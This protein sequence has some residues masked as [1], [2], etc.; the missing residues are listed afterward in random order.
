MPLCLPC[1]GFAVKEG[2]MKTNPSAREAGLRWRSRDAIPRARAM[3]KLRQ[4]RDQLQAALDALSA[5]VSWISSDLKYLGGNRYLAEILHLPQAAFA[6][7]EVGFQGTSPDLAEFARGFFASPAQQASREITSQVDGAIRRY[8]VVARKYQGGQAAAFV[9]MDITELREAGEEIRK[10][11]QELERRVAERTAQLAAANQELQ[12]EVVRR[13]RAEEKALRALDQEKELSDLKSRFISMTSHEFRTPLSMIL[14]S[15][16]LLEQ[17][18]HQL[19][20]ERVLNHLRRIQA[21]AKQ[22]SDLLDDVLIVAKSDVGKLTFTPGPLD[23]LRFCEELV[24]EVQLTIG[25]GHTV[26]FVHRGQ[27]PDVSMDESLLRQILYNLLSNAIH[28]SD[29]GSTVH[30]ELT[31]SDDR[32]TFRVSDQGIGI[33]PEE[34]ERLFEAFHR[35]SNAGHIPGTGLGLT[36]VKRAVDLHGGTITISSQVGKGTTFTVTIPSGYT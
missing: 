12:S 30:F 25:A 8:L 36:I 31:C 28:Y 6:G 14:S 24:E 5:A 35:A 23:I 4:A 22:M 33:P 1:G 13:N 3:N 7:K 10:L 15:A 17:Y 18:C 19:A 26:T 21:N 32:V 20:T 27:C 29:P 16:Q 11:N 34:Q 9:G 2:E